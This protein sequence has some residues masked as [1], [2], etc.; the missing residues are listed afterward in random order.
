MNVCAHKWL[1]LRLQRDGLHF[2]VILT[3]VS[4]NDSARRTAVPYVG[5]GVFWCGGAW[6]GRVGRVLDV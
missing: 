4:V 2:A 6:A 3:I 1:G 5:Q